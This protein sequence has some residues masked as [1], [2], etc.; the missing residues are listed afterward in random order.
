MYNPLIPPYA[1]PQMNTSGGDNNWEKAFKIYEKLERRQLK[2]EL[3]KEE[4][5]KKKNQPPKKLR[6]F[7]FFETFAIL[8]VAS[9]WLGPIIS[10]LQ[11]DFVGA[12][13]H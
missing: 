7:T 13:L 9:P 5:N 2:K 6:D 8:T 10:S 12:L 11:H 3:K 4:E 1:Y